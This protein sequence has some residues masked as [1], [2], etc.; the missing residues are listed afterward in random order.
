MSGEFAYVFTH[1]AYAWHL[2]DDI[3]QLHINGDDD[4]GT[5]YQVTPNV[6]RVIETIAA[7]AKEVAW[8]EA[9]DSDEKSACEDILKDLPELK[10]RIAALETYCLEAV[11]KT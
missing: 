4:G 8:A 7:I 10:A 11:K 1:G 3:A 6:G 5:S 9:G 2:L